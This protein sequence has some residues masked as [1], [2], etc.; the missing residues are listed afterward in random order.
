VATKQQTLKKSGRDVVFLLLIPI[1]ATIATLLLPLNLLVSTLLLFGLPCLYLSLQNKSIIKSSFIFALA[2]TVISLFTDYLAERD[3]SW[4]ST[5]IFNFR[6]AGYV[7]IEALVWMFLFTYL[8][9]A[10]YQYFFQPKIQKTPGKRMPLLYISSAI[11]LVWFVLTAFEAIQPFTISYFYIKFGLILIVLPL[12]LFTASFPRFITIF[13]KTAPYF[14]I[15]S[16]VNI[17]VS[18]EKGHWIYS[19]TNFI[20]WVQLGS[21]RFPVEELLFWII[22]YSSFAIT[23]YEFYNNDSL[24]F[25]TKL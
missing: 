9:V 18:L 1:I 21:Y 24:K 20:G 4:S 13:L 25:K 14:F 8:I 6:L 15:L 7:P 17:L 10:Y 3:Q 12:V 22:L 2:I 19:G 16:L 23:Q 11:V 5:T